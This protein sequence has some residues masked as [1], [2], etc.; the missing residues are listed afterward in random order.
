VASAVALGLSAY[1]T[2]EGF[3]ASLERQWVLSRSLAEALKSEAIK[4]IAHAPPYDGPIV[5][6][7]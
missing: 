6:T 4:F 1:C 7:C 5:R 2:K 3:D